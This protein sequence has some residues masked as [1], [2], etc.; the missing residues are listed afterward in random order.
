MFPVFSKPIRPDFG[1]W[2]QMAIFQCYCLNLLTLARLPRII[3]SVPISTSSGTVI[4][5][6]ATLAEL[7]IL[8][9]CWCFFSLVSFFFCR[10]ISEVG[11]LVNYNPNFATGCLT[12]PAMKPLH[13]APFSIKVTI[14]AYII[15]ICGW[16]FSYLAQ[17]IHLHQ[18]D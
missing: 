17:F 14:P 7:A 3:I 18:N 15:G 13:V 5:R 16:I 4:Q 2:K 10:L 11:Y 6:P 9:C 8:F 12:V 1:F